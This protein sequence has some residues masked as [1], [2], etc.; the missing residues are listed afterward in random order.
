LTLG[1]IFL[2]TNQP[3]LKRT[4]EKT[5]FELLTRLAN[6]EIRTN[7]TFLVRLKRKLLLLRE[8]EVVSINKNLVVSHTPIVITLLIHSVAIILKLHVQLA[9]E[10]WG[11]ILLCSEDATEQNNSRQNSKLVHLA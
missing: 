2:V 1:D 7:N 10:L 4:L 8:L 9:R 11:N 6:I 5:K 3:L